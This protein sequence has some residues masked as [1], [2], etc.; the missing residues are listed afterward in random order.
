MLSIILYRVNASVVKVSKSLL[1]YAFCNHWLACV[2]FMIHRY[3]ERESSLTWAIV[4]NL[5]VYDEETGH[6]D[7][8]SRDISYCYV[9]S[10]YFVLSTL[11]SVGYGMYC[12]SR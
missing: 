6:H 5:A 3:L 10:L 4:D 9:R 1:L 12:P 11:T 7:V 8:C 2:Y